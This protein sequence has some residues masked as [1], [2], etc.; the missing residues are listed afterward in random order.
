MLGVFR[1]HLSTLANG[2]AVGFPEPEV[3]PAAGRIGRREASEDWMSANPA[4]AGGR[5]P[6]CGVCGRGEQHVAQLV[7]GRQLLDEPDLQTGWMAICGECVA[8]AAT[9]VTEESGAP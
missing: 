8:S 1:Q 5:P 7:Q 9:I 4:G 3:E 2:T 6:S